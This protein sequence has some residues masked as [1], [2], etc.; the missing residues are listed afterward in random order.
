MIP[1]IH[2][3]F[4]VISRIS[5]RSHFLD[6]SNHNLTPLNYLW[7]HGASC[8]IWRLEKKKDR[9]NKNGNHRK[10]TKSKRLHETHYSYQN[11]IFLSPRHRWCYYSNVS[12]LNLFADPNA[13]VSLPLIFFFN[14]GGLTHE[15]C[16]RVMRLNYPSRLLQLGKVIE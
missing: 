5:H 9:L 1:H 8:M 6:A 12:V 3:R 2:W 15:I 14:H 13:H 7:W 4:R 16:I 11:L 10:I